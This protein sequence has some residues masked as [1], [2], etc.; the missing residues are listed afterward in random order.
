MDTLHHI[1][2]ILP[3]ALRV[4]EDRTSGRRSPR[5]QA[6]SGR[7]HLRRSRQDRD[8]DPPRRL[9]EHR[10]EW[11][12][13]AGVAPRLRH[14]AARPQ[15]DGP[16]HHSGRHDRPHP[17]LAYEERDHAADGGLSLAQS[18]YHNPQCFFREIV[19]WLACCYNVSQIKPYGKASLMQMASLS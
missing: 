13:V 17:A 19:P 12:A 5:A 11:E 4:P 16:D 8:S 3:G 1:A 9:E 7:A 14:A 2:R 15:A 6:G 10:Q 18:D